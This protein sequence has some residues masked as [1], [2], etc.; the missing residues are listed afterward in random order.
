MKRIS[1]YIL[2]NAIIIGTRRKFEFKY[3]KPLGL[4]HLIET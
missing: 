3:A 2:N 4:D 1:I